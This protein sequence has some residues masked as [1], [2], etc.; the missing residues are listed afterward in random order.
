MVLSYRL[1]VRQPVKLIRAF[2]KR[3][4]QRRVNRTAAD[5]FGSGNFAF[6]SL[7][8][9]CALFCAAFPVSAQIF[10][11]PTVIGTASDPTTI[12]KGDFNRDGK[13]DLAYLDGGG[14][15][16]LHI[17]LGNG[18]GTFQRAQDVSLPQGIG[19]TITVADVNNDGWPDLV[20]GGGGPQAQVA[21]LLG[22]GDGTFQAPIVSQF[23]AAG[24]LYADIGSVIGV[25]D[26]NGD[27]A[28]DLAAADIQNNAVYILLGNNT[29][30]FTL[31]T[32]L[33][34]GAGPTNVLT[35]DLN[36]DGHVDLVVQGFYGANAAVFM[37]NG[38]GTF[39]SGVAYSGP[40]NITGIILQDMDG[41]GKLDMVV[42]GFNNTVDILHGNGD[43][44][45]A[46][47]SEGG[48]SYAGPGAVLL[49]VAD[50]NSDGILDLVTATDNGIT[51]L[52]G[53]GSLSYGPPIPY[54]G[55]PTTAGAAM[56]DFNGD[57]YQDFA[58]IAPGGIALVFGAP[59]G[60]FRGPELYDLG[61]GLNS[62]AIADFNGDKIPDIAVN[63]AQSNPVILLGKG[64]GL[65]T[66]PATTG[67]ISGTIP[68]LSI[69]T[70]DFNGDGKPDLMFSHGIPNSS[71]SVLLGNGDG[72]FGS[73]VVP[74][75]AA[76]PTY[77]QATL[78]DFDMDGTTDIAVL[79]YASVDVLL[80]E[81]DGTFQVLPNSL[82]GLLPS[83]GIAAG[84]FNNDG[85]PDLIFTQDSSDP[86][87]TLIGNGNGTFTPGQQL[88]CQDFPQQIAVADLNGDGNQD[89]IVLEKFIDLAQI[90]LGNGNGTFQAPINLQL[91]REYG[92][93]AVADMN[94]DGKPDLVL[95]D[96]TLLAIIPNLGSGQFGLEQH[97]LAGSIASFAVSDV[98]G[99]GLPDIVVA[100]GATGNGNPATTVT[101]LINQGVAHSIAGQIS[102]SP[103]PSTYGQPFT[104]NLAITPQG[105]N[106]PAPTGTVAISVDDV[107]VATIPVN[108]LDLSYTD[109]DSSSLA[110]GSHTLEAVYSGDTNYLA[111][112]FSGQHVIA[113]I[114]Y[115][116]TT[117]L[118]AAPTTTAASQ[119]VRF[120]A[121]VTSPGQ[122]A[123]APNPL[124]GTVVFRDGS[125]NLGS[126]QVRSDGTA[127]F[128]TALLAPGSH[129]IAAYYLGY[130]A[131][132]EQ[133]ASFA[134]SNSLAVPVTITAVTTSVALSGQPTSISTGGIASLTAVVSSSSGT[135]RGA[136]TFLDGGTPLS[137]QPLDATGT[138]VIGAT[139]N[140]AGAHTLT[141]EY[142]PNAQ[143]AAS[144]SAAVSITVTSAP[145][146]SQSS[147]RLSVSPVSA[148]PSQVTLTTNVSVASAVPVGVVSFI[149]GNST[150]G[151]ATLDRLGSASFT[152]TLARPGLHYLTAVYGGDSRHQASV[153]ATVVERTP[154]NQPDFTLNA[155]AES[156]V[157]SQGKTASVLATFT[158]ING[159]SRMVNVTCTPAALG[160]LCQVR[161]S[162]LFTGRG[163]SL[164]VISAA[165]SGVRASTSSWPGSRTD[166]AAVLLVSLIA[167][168]LLLSWP[169]NRR[170][171]AVLATIWLLGLAFAAGCNAP[172]VASHDLTPVGDYQVIIQG[173]SIPTNGTSTLTH[174][175]QVQVE[176]IAPGTT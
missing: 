140:S 111:A 168:P 4:A 170:R 43:G 6:D 132:Y 33:F 71:V 130:T 123:N 120:T 127:V 82:P 89:I 148:S 149:D 51:I 81:R 31:K 121:T 103:E 37:G 164:L 151:A 80:G 35:S 42:S 32:T 159:F 145:Q 78:G 114:L 163:S 166:L 106:P 172:S 27:G 108:G 72:T 26:F 138:A 15:F 65:F 92:E 122:N 104:I 143:F 7:L 97:I 38:D 45:F 126:A 11:N 91:Q 46:T 61:E 73:P 41:D 160:I 131:Q 112:T 59:G 8:A 40:H 49:D 109:P 113:P 162:V 116:T 133:T 94:G 152:A 146:I 101:V 63:A 144:A 105:T 68:A 176:V 34:D 48:T 5:R 21:V 90:Y 44:T 136:V 135:P 2:V 83:N 153:S 173:S 175:V 110:V 36:G 25:A 171:V 125:T 141:A 60:T 30:S 67:G 50:L 62:L 76:T 96:G 115:P 9:I 13:I 100:N 84:D 3:S 57:G 150:L 18:D 99:D 24:S 137:T 167:G 53:Q 56:A 142:L 165:P 14:P 169:S 74:A 75:I 118:S 161:N 64:G 77:G 20:L 95:S 29:G 12:S 129:D 17:L 69:F 147:T 124:S 107:P 117:T 85:K 86:L 55:S 98:N 70:G 174:A 102:A 155:S 119:T 139:L 39:Q 157:V 19:G 128:D 79:D 154:L 52:L 28:V 22:N 54:S 47:T 10:K 66:V 87:Q 1:S 158:P 23:A 58:E 93:L 16:V 156:L 88:P 134:P